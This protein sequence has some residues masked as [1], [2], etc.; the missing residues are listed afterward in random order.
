MAFVFD[1]TSARAPY[2]ETIWH[3]RSE[4]AGTF[5]SEASSHWELVFTTLEG[6]TK[7]SARGPETRASK[8][9]FPG[10]A[11]YL[12][13]TFRLGTFM[14]HLPLK[15]LLDRQDPTLP[16]ASSSAFWLHGSAWELPTQET[17]DVFTERLIRQGILVRDPLV[18]AA[19]QGQTPDISLRA[20][21][22]RFVQA[23]GIPQKTTQQIARAQRAVLLLESGTSIADTALE[24]GYFDQAHLTNAL[25]R[26]VGRTP[27]QI[28]GKRL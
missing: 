2:I 15:T 14:P 26:F 25:R 5:V 21:Q 20:L 19:L 4:H 13:I 22:Q 7:V 16:A 18:E 17:A 27:A 24:L 10:D 3:T 8:A 23:T 1:E 6:R 28:A 11:E 9:D 12:G